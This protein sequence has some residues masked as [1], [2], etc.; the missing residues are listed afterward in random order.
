VAV[1]NSSTHQEFNFA[2]SGKWAAY[3]FDGYR[4]GPRVGREELNPEIAVRRT[5]DVLEPDA[6]LAP[7]LQLA[8]SRELS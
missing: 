2:P 1:K 3:R 4:N 8:A 5:N 7:A 6:V